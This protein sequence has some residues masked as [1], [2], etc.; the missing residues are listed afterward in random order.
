MHPA[1]ITKP[2]TLDVVLART[3]CA[4][5]LTQQGPHPV[6]LAAQEA[7]RICSG[8][9]GLPKGTL[10]DSAAVGMGLRW[11]GWVGSEGW[12][13]EGLGLGRLVGMAIKQHC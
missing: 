7:Q 1:E 9:G 8:Y 13:F 4:S 2:M 10:C 11:V 12:I 3:A 5:S 6:A